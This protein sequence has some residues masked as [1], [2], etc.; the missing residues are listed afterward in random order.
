MHGVKCFAVSISKEQQKNQACRKE[1]I[2]NMASV[3]DLASGMAAIQ[4]M[5]EEEVKAVPQ[6]YED[7]EAGFG[8]LKSER[9]LFP[10]RSVK[11]STRSVTEPSPLCL[12]KMYRGF[13]S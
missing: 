1:K 7:G 10:L 2:D 12:F 4:L 3:D 13:L 8:A 5:T 6:A 9:G 11:V